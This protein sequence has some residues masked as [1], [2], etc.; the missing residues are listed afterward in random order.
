MIASEVTAEA[1]V[2]LN[3]ASQ[4]LWTNTVLLPFL[5]KANDELERELQLN[6]IET[7]IKVTTDVAVNTGVLTIS[8]PADM[9]L[10]LTMYEKA[11]TGT[12]K[13]QLMTRIQHLPD[14]QQTNSLDYWVYETDLFKFVGALTNRLV[15]LEYIRFVTTITAA[16]TTI[17][18]GKAAKTALAARTAELAAGYIGENP[19][20]AAVLHDDAETAKSIYIRLCS[21]NMQGLGTRRRPYRAGVKGR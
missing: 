14:I 18:I 13:Y 15:R 6:G 20:R 10:P 12:E 9:F 1:A 7:I 3:D 11:A 2:L 8:A 17:D 19:E 4:T 16:G 21:K 5:S